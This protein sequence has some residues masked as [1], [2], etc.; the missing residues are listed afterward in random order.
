MSVISFFRF[1][2][3]LVSILIASLA[4]ISN[5]QQTPPPTTTDAHSSHPEKI[6]SEFKVDDS[7]DSVVA[8]LQKDDPDLKLLVIRDPNAP[9]NQ[10]HITL[11]LKNVTASDVLSVMSSIYPN[12][13]LNS[14]SATTG[15][16]FTLKIVAP[17]SRDGLFGGPNQSG[18]PREEVKVYNLTLL[19]DG[20][21][22][23]NIP[24]DAKL[25]DLPTLRRKALD[26][27]MSLVQAAL[28]QASPQASKPVLQ[29]H[30]P[31]QTL[32]FKGTAEQRGIVQEAMNALQQRL[33]EQ[34]RELA[35]LKAMI[36][37]LSTA[38]T[39]RP[40]EPASPDQPARRE[41]GGTA[42]QGSQS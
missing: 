20:W 42:P 19:V 4:A 14:I 38:P 21:I 6:F 27:I 39:T 17:P 10:P 22:S 3:A 15:P 41:R 28:S 26:Q 2:V 37:S 34:Q 11:S 1:R 32:V 30:E 12:V 13:A 8:R 18:P 31:T 25:E 33:N 24:P 40:A 29:V 9:P 36:G 5:A 35:R 7:I 23:Q 16:I